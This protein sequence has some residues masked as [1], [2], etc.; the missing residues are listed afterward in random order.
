M[1]V[2]SQVRLSHGRLLIVLSIFVISAVMTHEAPYA[3]SEHE[4]LNWDIEFEEISIDEG[5]SQSIVECIIQDRNGFMWFGTEDGLNK[6]DGYT[7]TIMRHDPDDAT[8]IS[9]NHILALC[10]DRKGYIWIGT[11]NGGL[12]KY[13]TFTGRFSAYRHRRDNPRSLSHDYINTLYVD[14]TGTLWIGTQNGLNMYHEDTDDFT[15]YLHDPDDPNSISS[16]IIRDIV[17]DRSGVLWI[18]T[19]GEGLNSFDRETGRF[20]V[21][22][23]DPDDRLSLSHNSVRVLYEDR[24]GVLWVGTNGGGLNRFDKD[25]EIFMR[26]INDPSDPY[27]LSHNQ[28]YALYE[29]QSGLFWVG[30][31]GG[32]LNL[33]DREEGRSYTF[34]NDPNDPTSLSY[35]EIYD[36]Y[37]DRSGVMWLGTYGGGVNKFDLK[38]KQFVTYRPDP[39]DPN[40]L[41][42]EIVWSICEDR[43]GIL[44]IG[45]HG[46]G[47]NR[48]DR[49]TGRYTHYRYDRNDPTSIGSDIVRNVFIDRSG[50]FWIGTHGGGLN[51]F[52][53]DTDRFVRFQNDPDEPASI[54]SNEL[55]YIYEDHQGVLWI[56]TNGGGLNKFDRASETF[57]RYRSDPNDPTS[58]S[59]DYIRVIYEDSDGNFWIGTQG[60]GLEKFDRQAGTFTHYRHDPENANSISN[61]FVF[62]IHEDASGT[63]W[64]GTW[65]G[66]LARFDR[67]T[68]TFKHYTEKD[69]LPTNSIYGLLEDG[70]GNFWISTN[71][72]VAKFDPRTERLKHYTEEDGLQS[73]EFNGSAFFKSASGE[74]FFGGIDGFNS[75]YPED[76]KDNPFIPPVVITSFLKLNKKVKLDSAISEMHK[77]TLSHKD[78]VFSFEFSSLDFT[79]P[80]KNAYAYKMEGLD[81]EW[82][83]TD[84]EKRFATYTT[85]APGKYRFRVKGS[86]NDGV[87]NED[88]TAIELII[89]PPLW[90]TFWFQALVILSV[91]SLVIFLYQRRLRNVR[92]AAELRAAH[93]AQM[94]IMP[95]A[96]PEVPGFDISGICIPANEVGGDFYEYFW[97]TADNTKFGV[98]VGDVSGKAMSAAMIAVMSSGMIYLRAAADGSTADIM[99]QLNTPIYSKTKEYIFTTLCLTALDTVT[100]K[101]SFTNAGFNSPLLISNGT[102]TVVECKG[103]RLPLGAIEHTQYEESTVRLKQG[104]V[105]IIFSDGI[106]DARN[107]T[108][109]FYDQER[110]VTLLAG[111]DTGKLTA[112]DIKE[113]IVEDVMTFAGNAPQN[114]DMTVVVIKTV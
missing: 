89:T 21:Y 85:L 75:F 111:T 60:G 65:G 52:D 15:R 6:Y 67:T 73:N 16:N 77:L 41:S 70:D 78:Y 49:R 17:E 79:A 12:N 95:S 106:P 10:E 98:A 113:R 51:R 107:K 7:F 97:M 39:N 90:R 96:D 84:S 27:S 5:L 83:F 114:D 8:S 36:I 82:I 104:D 9:Y 47:L 24:S 18:A 71:Y 44:W 56:G 64:L 20:R 37:E 43:E 69:G 109:E 74:M 40:S 91:L 32:G 92:M 25:L 94:S 35:D 13:N 68:E 101:M 103:T 93:A 63:L 58:L 87:W 81:E 53:P 76:I 38:R 72:G 14:N 23:H 55:R 99:T 31:N 2:V 112:R 88:G 34:R 110:L 48:F 62:S 22:R 29:D 108:K 100:R 28:V 46:G 86:N 61:D 57:T 3:A 11:F 19:D 105:V 59:N 50:V 102:V 26:F 30:T 33:F 45:T 42:E 80:V 1:R 4:V 66:G 54:S